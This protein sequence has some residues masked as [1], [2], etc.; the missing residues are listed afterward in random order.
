MGCEHCTVLYCAVLYCIVLC[1]TVLYCIVLYCTVL[2]CIVQYIAKLY[3]VVLYRGPDPAL[4]C[5]SLTL[6]APIPFRSQDW[7]D[8]TPIVAVSSELF[9]M[10]SFCTVLYCI[11][12]YYTVLY[13]IVLYCTLLN[14]SG[15]FHSILTIYLAIYFGNIYSK[16]QKK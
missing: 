10:F 15:C 13:C 6:R 14:C 4:I 9:G 11:V 7:V 8:V 12:L 16:F 3:S 2:Y 1:C 5:H